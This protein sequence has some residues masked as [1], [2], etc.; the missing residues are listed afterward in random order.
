MRNK[1][2]SRVWLSVLVSGL[3]VSA[4][5]AAP[6]VANTTGTGYTRPVHPASPSKDI[7]N[8]SNGGASG[9]I[10]FSG[11]ITSPTCIVN[12][13]MNGENFDVEMPKVSTADLRSAGQ[14]AGDTKFS[15]GL[16]SC[17]YAGGKV[18]A[19]FQN[20]ATVDARTGRLKLQE[21]G[22]GVSAS[23]VQVELANADGAP[24]SVGEDQTTAYFPIDDAGSAKMDYVA[25]YYA[26][27]KTRAGTVHSQVTYVLQYE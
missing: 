27:G 14:I 17:G 4:A 15:I 20:G 25:R 22:N 24:I 10:T 18:R 9:T 13:G 2:V 23:N 6:S 16:S 7:P 5:H 21:H 3:L 12:S 11:E 19:Y 8:Q 1:Y 26:T